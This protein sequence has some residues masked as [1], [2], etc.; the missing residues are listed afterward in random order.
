[1][2]DRTTKVPGT[3]NATVAGLFRDENKAENAIEDLKEA[4]FSEA[5][6]GIATTHNEEKT[7]FWNNIASKFGKQEHTDQAVELE[8][9]L[10]ESGIPEQQA[11]YFNSQLSR[12]G[13][14]VTVR[15][16]AE[17]STEAVAILQQN[18]ADA[19]T[20][21]AEWDGGGTP[22]VSEQRMQLVGEIL[23][24]H[25]DRVSRGE[26]RLRKEIIT[27]QQNIEVPT[28]REELVIERT[29]AGDQEASG[30]GSGEKEIRIPLSEEQVRV[31]KKPVVTEDIRIGKREVQ[32]TKRVSEQ[33]QHE[34]LRTETEGGVDE[35]EI[36]KAREK[37]RKTA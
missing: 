31:E 19:G 28:T 15:A 18:G 13:A 32:D 2:A 14:L 35:E 6:I 8:E 37:R 23:R 4:G 24:V 30:I 9:S 12:G 33:V 10:R 3:T 20:A 27:E 11:S 34:E 36:Q 25:K 29:Y 21:A 1:M 16:G 22:P 17:R 5:Q 7:G 26:V